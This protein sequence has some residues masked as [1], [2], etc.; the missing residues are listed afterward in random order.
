MGRVADV[1]ANLLYYGDNLEILRGHVAAGFHHSPLWDAHFPRIQIR[2]IQE[3][4]TGVRPDLPR[5][6]G[7]LTGFAKAPRVQDFGSQ[8]S[9]LELEG[10]YA[11]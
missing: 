2:T 1:N 9:I 5:E 8:S 11:P 6:S 7:R 10:T 4:L 3:L